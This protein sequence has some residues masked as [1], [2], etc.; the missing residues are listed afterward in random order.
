[1]VLPRF[2]VRSRLDLVPLFQS[3]GVHDLFDAS[4]ADLSGIS[5]APGLYVDTFVHEAWVQ[6][7]EEGTEAAA[8]TGAAVR[9]VLGS[10][11]I[12]CDHPFLFFI[13]DRVS[14]ALLFAGRVNDPSQGS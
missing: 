5:A 1:V 9:E 3:L 11:P 7:D 10:L 2:S 13:R 12:V 8:A 6:V 4:K 14:G